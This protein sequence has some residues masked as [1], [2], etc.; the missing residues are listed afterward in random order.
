MATFTK[1][2]LKQAFIKLLDEHP[3][4]QI[5]VKD[6]VNECGVNRNTFYYYF[7][8]I[9]NLIEDIVTEDAE[10]II[11]QYPTVEK[12][13]NCLSA[14]IE[15]AL[16]KRRAV[17]HIYNSINREIYEQYLWRV[18]GYIIDA[19]LN[20]ILNGRKISDSD[21]VIIKKYLEGVGFGIIS[22]WLMTGMTEDI[23]T[24]FYRICE[25]K[26]GTVEEMIS[27]CELK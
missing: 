12:I 14:V 22:G 23:L 27:R 17:L 13:E 19:Y 5:T 6:I 16:S 26:K 7:E 11:Q 25:I 21:L 24:V 2:A 15:T 3:L 20:T 8:D 9:P 4:S 10:K 18:C 1:Q